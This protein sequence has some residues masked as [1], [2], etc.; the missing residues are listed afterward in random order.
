[1]I[2]GAPFPFGQKSP[3]A[4]DQRVSGFRFPLGR[5]LRA[6]ARETQFERVCRKPEIC[7]KPGGSDGPSIMSHGPRTD[8][9][10]DPGPRG[11]QRAQNGRRALRARL[12]DPPGPSRPPTGL[13]RPSR[14]L[15]RPDPTA[16]GRGGKAECGTHC[17]PLLRPSTPARRRGQ[18]VQSG[19]L[20]ALDGWSA[21]RLRVVA[22]VDHRTRRAVSNSSL[23]DQDGAGPSAR[24]RA[25]RPALAARLRRWSADPAANG[26]QRAAATESA[27]TT[28]RTSTNRA[29]QVSRQFSDANRSAGLNSRPRG[30]AEDASGGPSGE[31]RHPRG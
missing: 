6:H 3:E 30:A 31:G 8:P 16:L 14:T 26:P 25:S 24:R 20:I 22:L 4:P 7:R 9:Q 19:H 1:M 18:D 11:P 28:R 12:P 13:L 17:Y 21:G 10:P 5:A 29:P 2:G 15:C 23:P 27:S